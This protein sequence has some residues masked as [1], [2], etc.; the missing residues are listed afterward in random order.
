V[1]RTKS[2]SCLTATF[3]DRCK[4]F[5]WAACAA[6]TSKS[7]LPVDNSGP[8]PEQ[9]NTR[10]RWPKTSRRPPVFW[11]LFFALLPAKSCPEVQEPGGFLGGSPKAAP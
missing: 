7:G 11:S 9:T 2:A 1:S 10:K 8:V 6:C 3:G 4:G 5:T